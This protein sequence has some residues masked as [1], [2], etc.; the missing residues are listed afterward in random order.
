MSPWRFERRRRKLVLPVDYLIADKMSAD[1][2][3]K[4]VP[5]PDIPDGWEGFDV[6]PVTIAAWGEILKNAGTVV[7]NGPLGKFEIEPFSKGTRHGRGAGKLQSNHGR[8]RRRNRRG[9]RSI[10]FRRQSDARLH[11][12]RCVFGV[13]GGKKI[14]FPQGDS[15]SFL[16]EPVS[17]SRRWS[18]PPIRLGDESPKQGRSRDGLDGIPDVFAMERSERLKVWNSILDLSLPFPAQLRFRPRRRGVAA[19]ERAGVVAL[20]LDVMDGHFVPNLSY[21]SGHRRLAEARDRPF[22]SRTD[23][24]RTRAVSR[25][26]RQGRLRDDSLHIEVVPDPRI[27]CSHP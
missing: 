18:G 7:W 16:I 10:R 2:K 4:V 27:D 1:A 11:R 19:L 14:Q 23:D 17:P 6:G 5:G 20:H 13:F 15:R 21:G 8:R 24:F 26:L 3:T 25:R 9:G 22:R 12:R